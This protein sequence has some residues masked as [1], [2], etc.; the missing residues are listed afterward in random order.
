ML[1]RMWH[2]ICEWFA[3]P[4]Y[5][6][7]VPWTWS[8]KEPPQQ[9]PTA[10]PHVETLVLQRAGIQVWNFHSTTAAQEASHG[11]WRTERYSQ[12]ETW[13]Q[14]RQAETGQEQTS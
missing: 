10:D 12:P 4:V 5:L 13:Q 11:N 8:V 2:R 6:Q 7:T 9:T 1:T 14:A 3:E